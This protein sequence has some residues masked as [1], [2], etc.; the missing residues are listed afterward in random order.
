MPPCFC[1]GASPHPAGDRSFPTS[2]SHATH[3]FAA[4]N[5]NGPAT[6]ALSG[7]LSGPEPGCPVLEH[8]S[9]HSNGSEAPSGS[10]EDRG[11]RIN[12]F[13]HAVCLARNRVHARVYVRDLPMVHT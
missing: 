12:G 10:S 7:R 9:L 2:P 13:S 5:G 11:I 4:C 8:D 3:T 6:T 1:E